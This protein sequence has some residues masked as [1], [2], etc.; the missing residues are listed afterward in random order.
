MSEQTLMFKCWLWRWWRAGN[1]GGDTDGNFRKWRQT[2]VAHR[3]SSGRCLNRSYKIRREWEILWDEQTVVSQKGNA[4]TCA[5][6]VI[7]ATVNYSSKVFEIVTDLKWNKTQ[8][9]MLAACFEPQ[10]VH[11]ANYSLHPE[12]A[13]IL[14][15]IILLAMIAA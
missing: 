4:N 11:C 10:P 9:I 8:F 1:D 5:H 7:T 15:L 6:I 13:A 2:L 12:I 14:Y 3:T